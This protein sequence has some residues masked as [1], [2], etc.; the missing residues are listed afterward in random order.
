MK[1]KVE[2]HDNL[3][4]DTKT[5]AVL[6]TDMT[7]L[8]AYKQR[9]ESLRKKDKD[10]ESLKNEVSELKDLVQKLLAEKIK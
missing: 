4:R 1:V 7:S 10:L 2:N 3:V 9:R 8:Q 6:N 5:K